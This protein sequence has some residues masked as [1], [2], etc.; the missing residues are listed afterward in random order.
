MTP[1]VAPAMTAQPTPTPSTTPPEPSPV[2][3]TS[4]AAG[5]A[6]P[7]EPVNLDDLIG[8]RRDIGPLT[9]RY[10]DRLN[11]RALAC[12][13]S[14]DVHLVAFVAN[15][16]GLGGTVG[17]TV[18]PAWLD[19]WS[20]PTTFVAAS[21]S[22]SIP[23][24]FAGP[25]WP[26]AVPPAVRPAFEAL[27]G[28]WASVTGRFDAPLAKSCSF[29]FRGG[30]DAPSRADLIEM[31]RTSFVVGTVEAAPD[32]CPDGDGLS[33]VLAT[34]EHLRADCFAGRALSFKA[35]GTSI[36]NVW[37]GLSV[38]EGFRDWTFGG[39]GDDSTLWAFVPSALHLPGPA[40]TPWENRDTVGGPDVR[41]SVTGHFDDRLAD[42]C[43]PTDGD[44]VDGTAVTMS[45]SQAWAFC[46]NHFVVDTLTWLKDG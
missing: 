6:C 38:P 34:P 7:T 13:G 8:L 21:D 30:S 46:R 17:Y 26:V 29:G 2:A 18:S 27:R 11:E 25:F 42:D 35:L 20:S 36:N 33:S 23:G 14:S 22:E 19:T 28:R 43:V 44:T 41:W 15:P 31:C 24:A 32:P 12:I 37:P 3:S 5:P 9:T 4:A 39:P 45:M 16:E 10:T 1:T 40:G